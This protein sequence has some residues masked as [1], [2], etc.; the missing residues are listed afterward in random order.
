MD[1][2]KFF[3]E[4]KARI[5]ADKSNPKEMVIVWLTNTSVLTQTTIDYRRSHELIGLLECGKLGLHANTFE[6]AP[7]SDPGKYP[8]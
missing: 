3:K 1:V 6:D 7:D 8:K 4:V 2:D 5:K